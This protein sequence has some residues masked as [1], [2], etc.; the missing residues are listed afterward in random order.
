MRRAS[1]VTIAAL[2]LRNSSS[3]VTGESCWGRLVAS[4]F[5]LLFCLSIASIAARGAVI[6]TATDLNTPSG[7]GQVWQY[8][9][10][11][12]GLTLQVNQGFSIYFSGDLYRDLQDPPP[13]VNADWSVISVQPDLILHQPG[14]YD[15]QALRD[16]PSLADTFRVTFVWLGLGTPGSQPYDIYNADYSIRFSGT[17]VVT[18]PE[19]DHGWVVLVLILAG[20]VGCDF[21][22]VIR[23]RAGTHVNTRC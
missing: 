9:Y 22:R 2:G 5:I 13:S 19:P 6:F 10:T 7:G 8:T 17:T 18:V 16:S 11:L 12:T 20:V 23:K 3:L 14:F 4:P 21:Y 15:G 1:N